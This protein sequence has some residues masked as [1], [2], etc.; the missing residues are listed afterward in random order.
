MTRGNTVEPP[1]REAQNVGK[2]SN[3]IALVSARISYNP[4]ISLEL[5]SVVYLA[6]K[7]QGVKV[8][9]GSRTNDG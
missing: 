1:T 6:S 2:L 7:S 9:D 8:T 4:S 3:R 5:L